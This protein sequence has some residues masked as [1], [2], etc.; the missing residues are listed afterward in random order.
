MLPE[1]KVYHQGQM[2]RELKFQHG[3]F[4]TFICGEVR[5]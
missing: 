4:F 5:I 2:I 3:I 1:I